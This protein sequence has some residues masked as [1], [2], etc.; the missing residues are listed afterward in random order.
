[1]AAPLSSLEK[2]MRVSR[3]SFSFL[4]PTSWGI[5]HSAIVIRSQFSC[6]VENGPYTSFLIYR[7]QNKGT[8][9]AA[10]YALVTKKCKSDLQ[11]RI[12]QKNQFINYIWACSGYDSINSSTMDRWYSDNFAIKESIGKGY[13][14]LA[15]SS[16][17]FCDELWPPDII[18]SLTMSYTPFVPPTRGLLILF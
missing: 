7:G 3:S 4:F 9:L 2:R 12:N 10:N 15:V 18:C 17:G 16:A 13:L 1:M 14:C 8:L 6:H 11:G 5:P